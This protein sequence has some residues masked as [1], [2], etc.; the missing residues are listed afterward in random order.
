MYAKKAMH[1]DLCYPSNTLA[2][3]A[4]SRGSE[5][6]AAWL[7]TGP[8]KARCYEQVG[9]HSN[10]FSRTGPWPTI[11]VCVCGLSGESVRVNLCTA[12]IMKQTTS[13]KEHMC[14][15]KLPR[16]NK[17]NT[18]TQQDIGGDRMLTPTVLPGCQ[19]PSG[20][21]LSFMASA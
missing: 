8:A 17:V 6:Q 12:I 13:E 3:V 19:K 4:V 9:S 18:Y 2:R 15:T 5:Q 7:S 14:P 20:R 16:V 10:H 1:I 21:C 11:R